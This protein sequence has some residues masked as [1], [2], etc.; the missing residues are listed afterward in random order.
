MAISYSENLDIPLL[1]NGSGNWGAVVNGLIE[2]ID[3]LLGL[4]IVCDNNYVVID[5]N[6]VIW[7]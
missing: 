4:E 3:E 1:D 6:D 7:D 2:I 5:E